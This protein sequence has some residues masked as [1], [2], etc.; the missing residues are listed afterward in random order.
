M[1]QAI[2]QLPLTRDLLARLDVED[3]LG[4]FRERFH[5]PEGLIY[6]DGNS[7]GALPKTAPARL[8]EVAEREWGEHL[9][10]G[11]R[12][13]GWMTYPER[14]GNKIARLIGAQAGEIIAVD[15]TSLNLFKILAASLALKPTR[16]TIL[17]DTGNFPTDLYMAQ[18]LIELLGR[19]HRLKLVEPKEIEAAIDDDTVLVML[20]HVDYRSGR[21]HD[22]ERITRAAQA[23][24][25]IMLWDLCH[26]AGAVPVNLTRAG[27]DFAVGCGYKYLNGGPGAP[28]FIYVAQRHHDRTSQPLTGWLGHADPFAFAAE[29]RPAPGILHYKCSTPSILALAPLECGVDIMLEAGMPALRQKSM[30]LGDLFIRLV[31]ERLNGRGFRPACP[32]AAEE[33]G[34]QVSFHHDDGYAIMQA[35][36]ERRVVGD[37]RAP[38][39]MRFGLTPAYVRYVDV[40]DA[41]QIL[42]QIMDSRAYDKPEFKQRA[43]VT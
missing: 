17:S 34:S 2:A 14:L 30:A 19:R 27:A 43:S 5:L 36:I 18:G 1:D 11:W 12:K 15:T 21:I 3:P 37:F 31:A 26:S 24:G 42:A 38:D 6:L 4:H 35:L 22:M 29:Y 16:R 10:G 25:A 32:L 33:R 8:A 9:I 13:D 40:W 20:T 23:K 28:A 7:L 41:V 39:I